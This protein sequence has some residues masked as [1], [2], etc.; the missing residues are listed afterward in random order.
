MGL[1]LKR[2]SM[3]LNRLFETQQRNGR[4]SFWERPSRVLPDPKRPLLRKQ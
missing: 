2:A 1:P 3:A 4:P